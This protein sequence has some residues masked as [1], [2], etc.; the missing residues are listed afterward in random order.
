MSSADHH[1]RRHTHPSP[2]FAREPRR[3]ETQEGTG[4]VARASS[5][6]TAVMMI[7][8]LVAAMALSVVASPAAA[9]PEMHGTHAF[10]TWD[11]GHVTLDAAS[12]PVM[13]YYPTDGGGPFPVVAVVHGAGR[14]MTYMAEM[15]RTFAS[16]GFVALTPSIPCTPFACDHAANARQIRALLE[17]GVTSSAGAT[18]IAGLVDG[19]RRGVV[20]HSW[21]GLAV[22]LAAEGHPE[23][24]AVVTLD[25]ND[26]A[27]VAANAA[28][29]VTQPS[30]HLMA[31]V[32]GACNSTNW[33]DTV[34][35]HTP[36]PHLRLVV[37]GAG[38]C[39]VEDPTDGLCPLACTAGAGSS[40]TPVFRRYAVAFMGCMLQSDTTMAPYVGGA[41]LSADTTAGTIQYVAQD[42]LD[43]LPCYGGTL[44]D[45]GP[46]ESDAAIVVVDASAG[47]DAALPR[48]DAGASVDAASTRDAASAVDAA[49]TP[50][51][52]AGGC[53]FGV[54]R[55]RAGS[56]WLALAGTLLLASRRSR[57][58]RK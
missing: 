24:D 30:A 41:A 50:A 29:S 20:G 40:V 26:D 15:A 27:S 56:I 19:E 43:T 25:P 35:P 55:P 9:Q 1:E 49:V 3:R 53:G 46:S 7:R 28:P 5:V 13:A 14:N 54:T 45:A 12:I 58:R 4:L 6:D 23:I 21:G 33:K 52:D 57:R 10:T 17:W 37:H 32:M 36:S 39:D 2:F 34:F 47:I 16:R 8:L 11:A 42:G 38:H 18:P 31:E 22:F 48:V 44:P 51:S